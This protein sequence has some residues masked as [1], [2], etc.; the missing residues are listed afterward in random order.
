MTQ[1]QTEQSDSH[2]VDA[3]IAGLVIGIVISFVIYLLTV[4]AV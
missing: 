4:G 3:F 1:T 2:V